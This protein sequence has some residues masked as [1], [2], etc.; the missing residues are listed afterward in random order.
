[1]DTKIKA[2]KL[3]LQ[4]TVEQ[5]KSGAGQRA[6]APIIEVI[7]STLARTAIQRGERGVLC[8]VI[9]DRTVPEN[10]WTTLR[11]V[12]DIVAEEWTE[13]VKKVLESAFVIYSP[14]KVIVRR[15]VSTG[16]AKESMS[17]VLRELENRKFTHLAGDI[18]SLE[19]DAT[20]IAW[21]KENII[22][23]GIVYVSPFS[24]EGADSCS[25]VQLG[26]QSFKHS[27]FEGS[28]Y[29][30]PYFSIMLAGAMAGCPLNRS[31]DNIKIPYITYVNEVPEY[32]E[33][34]LY[35]YDDDGDFRVLSAVNSKT[36]YDSTWKEDTKYIKIF[37][38]INIVRFD[39]QNTFKDSW[40]GTYLNTYENKMAFCNIVN[41]VYF[42]ELA[43]EVLSPDYDNRIGIDIEANKR[44]IITQGDDPELMSE[45][46]IKMYPTGAKVFLNGQCKFT[47][48]MLDL[49]LEILY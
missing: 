36:T 14:S 49:N 40:L 2:L 47:N 29:L 44:Y 18:L 1:M 23:K 20:I 34:K 46:E 5:N 15:R 38:G 13:D 21:V 17:S 41:D 45:T 7:F 35:L 43:P 3:E 42:K 30:R 28:T 32:E 9:D 16:E 4:R 24:S 48:V 27:L 33:G 22:K 37:E 11:S 26:N 39:I 8:V 12:S 31:L 19:D 25:V 10:K 6:I